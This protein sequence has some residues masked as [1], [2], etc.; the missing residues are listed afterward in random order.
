MK[1]PWKINETEVDVELSKETEGRHLAKI[2]DKTYQ[3]WSHRL[4]PNHWYVE[5]NGQSHHF[6]LHTE[7]SV[8]YISHQGNLYQVED[9]S[10]R[11]RNA[12]NAHH[13][14]DVTP[15]MPGSIVRILVSEGDTITQGQELIVLSAMKMETTLYAPHNGKVEQILVKVG[16]Q[17]MPGQQLF[18]ITPIDD[19]NNAVQ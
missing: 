17:V 6:H 2:G 5:I 12:Q 16:E 11:R 13:Q 1:Y 8:R 19:T 9:R 15:P 18:G 3:V 10:I 7:G 4:S 14:G